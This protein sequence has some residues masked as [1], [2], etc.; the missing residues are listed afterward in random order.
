MRTSRFLGVAMITLALGVSACSGSS[1]AFSG[2]T[3]GSSSGGS[4]GSGSLTVGGADFTEM[5][6]MEQMYGQLLAKAGYTV[7]YKTAGNRE[8]YAKSLES[9]EIDVVPEYAATMAEYLNQQANGPDAKAIATS[10]PATTVAAMTPLAKAKGLSVLTPAQAADQNGFAVS[11][12]FADANH[13]TTLSQLA[14]LK[15]PIRLA[16]VVE[17]P[18]RPFCSP[19]LS[20]TYG[21]NITQILP[22]GFGS[23]QAKQAVLDGKADLALVGTTDATLSGLGLVLLEDDKHLQLADNLVP[24]VNA[25]SAGTPEVAKVLD[26]LSAVLTTE[27][28]AQLDAQVDAQRLKPADVAR[29]YLQSKGLL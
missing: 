18:K 8:I 20:S 3:S 1:D 10:D 12:K 7:D 22:L 21:L 15:K 4:G 14:A 6:I 13:I 25:A 23:P 24:V 2:S 9:G 26:K 29:T 5:L 17:C 16:A 28:L 19:G 11:K 27:D